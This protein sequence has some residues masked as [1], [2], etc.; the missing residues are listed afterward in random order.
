MKNL[1]IGIL[2]VA[3]IGISGL[4]LRE[5]HA[6]SRLRYNSQTLQLQVD[7]LQANLR[8]EQARVEQ[9]RHK[10]E[11]ARSQAAEKGREAAEVAETLQSLTNRP[12]E[13]A[14]TPQTNAIAELFKNPD[15][16]KMIVAQ[17]KTALGVM[18][19]K[20]YGAL[21]KQLNLTP[22]QTA[23]LKDLLLTK[24]LAAADA[25]MSLFTGGLDATN[26]AAMMAQIKTSSDAAGAQIKQFLG[27]N[28]FTQYQDYEKTIGERMVVGNFKDQLADGASPLTDPQEQQLIDAMT[29]ERQKFKF[30][31]D[32]SDQSKFNGDFASMLNSDKMNTFF[33]EQD[34]LNQNYLSR[35][36]GILTA[37]Q[38]TEFQKYLDAQ[39]QMQKAG[40]QMA[41]KIFGNGSK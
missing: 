23:A 22:E 5:Q 16:K 15:M 36:Q 19:D 39:K 10:V 32:L 11:T 37:D 28:N 17:Q 30:T 25:G 41:A 31:S 2:L 35:A 40:M 29:Q 3:T 12:A 9:L 7:E 21:F 6:A 34:Q 33:Q 4:L 1:I 24:Q 13:A 14:E 38:L 8:Q 18:I 26:R 20:N 27:D